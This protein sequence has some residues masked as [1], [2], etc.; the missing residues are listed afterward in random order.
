MPNSGA[1]LRRLQYRVEEWDLALRSFIKGL[2]KEVILGGDLNVGHQPI[3]VY[4][5]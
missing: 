3:D 4:N 1:G 5:Y 2:N